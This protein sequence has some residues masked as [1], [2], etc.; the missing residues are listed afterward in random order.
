MHIRKRPGSETDTWANRAIK[1]GPGVLRRCSRQ[2]SNKFWSKDGLR[3]NLSASNSEKKN[4]AGSAKI[5]FSELDALRSLLRP[6][7]DQNLL[8]L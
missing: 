5:F 7:L 4:L 8:L 3:S 6:S 1:H 2:S